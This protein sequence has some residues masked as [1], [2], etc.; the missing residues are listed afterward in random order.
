MMCSA[1]APRRGW[2]KTREPRSTRSIWRSLRAHHVVFEVAGCV[3]F[4]PQTDFS[5]DRRLEYRVVRRDE[6]GIRS[7]AAAA[8]SRRATKCVLEREFA[9]ERRLEIGA[10]DG[11]LQFVPRSA[12]GRELLRAIAEAHVAPD[13][14]V[15]FPQRD[16]VLG[17]VVTD[18]K[19]V[20][21]RLHVEEDAR[22][23]VRVA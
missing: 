23:A 2:R 5:P 21:V 16:V 9:V 11:E 7:G 1:T 19:P 22:G 17:I 8:G 14:V 13:A 6:I 12:V 3:G 4:C 15:E 20:A 10:V 18:R